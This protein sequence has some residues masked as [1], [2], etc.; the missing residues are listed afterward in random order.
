MNAY[1]M[2]FDNWTITKLNGT[3]LPYGLYDNAK[4][5]GYYKTSD[6]AK[7]EI[8][9]REEQKRQDIIGQNSNEGLHYE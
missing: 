1:Y 5:I 9:E 2:K 3:D 4:S 8:K 6:E 7:A